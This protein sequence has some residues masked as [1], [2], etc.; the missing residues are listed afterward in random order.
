MIKG[1]ISKS[2]KIASLNIGT[3]LFSKEEL[4]VNTIKEHN[5]NILGVSEIDIQYFNEKKP[6]STKGYNRFFPLE[7]LDSN[8]KRLHPMFC[9]EEYSSITKA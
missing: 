8:T 5:I 1:N 3:G 7:R 4:L 2:L 9:Q 6:Y